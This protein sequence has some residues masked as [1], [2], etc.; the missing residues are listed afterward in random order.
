MT[1]K[2]Q[3]L[4]ERTTALFALAEEWAAP[5]SKRPLH[6]EVSRLSKL[7]TTQRKERDQLYL[8]EP[9]LRYAYAAYFTPLNAAKIANLLFRLHNENKLPTLERPPRIADL[10]SGPCSGILGAHLFYGALGECWAMDRSGKALDDGVALYEQ[11]VGEEVTNLTTLRGNLGAKP[12]PKSKH[13]SFDVV[14]MANVL[15]EIGDP[16]RGQALRLRIIQN[17]LRLLS[18]DGIL[19]IVEPGT[20]VH[21]RALQRLRDTLVKTKEHQILSPCPKVQQCPLLETKADWCHQELDWE[22]PKVCRQIEKKAGL[23]SHILKCAHL[24]IGHSAFVMPA[25]AGCVVGGVMRTPTGEKR[26]M[27]QSKGLVTLSKGSGALPKSIQRMLRGEALLEVPKGVTC[28]L[29]DRRPLV[30]NRPRR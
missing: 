15:N 5:R 22:R 30:K 19:L 18:K 17:A 20:R 27:C 25:S 24:L 6:K 29:R 28:Q 14:I 2:P 8:S 3:L 1:I 23:E 9:G 26:Y 12:L 21:G 11:M 10:G 4:N 7:F 16:R 13:G